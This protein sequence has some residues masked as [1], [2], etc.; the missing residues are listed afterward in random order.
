MCAWILEVS[1]WKGNIYSMGSLLE[2]TCLQLNL[3]L[4]QRHPHALAVSSSEKKEIFDPTQCNSGVT[5]TTSRK[6]CCR[7]GKRSTS[8]TSLLD[9]VH[10]HSRILVKQASNFC[11]LMRNAEAADASQ[12]N[13]YTYP[14][15]LSTR[16]TLNVQQ[17]FEWG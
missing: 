14:A 16:G 8:D 4:I 7:L 5:I 2:V 6:C 12:R 13:S 11:L 9:A 17:G 10:P 1:G 15:T 3:R